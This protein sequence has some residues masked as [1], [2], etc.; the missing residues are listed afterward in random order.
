MRIAANQFSVSLEHRGCLR[1]TGG[2]Y[3]LG[4]MFR[5]LFRVPSTRPNNSIRQQ[6]RQ[7]GV[8][9]SRLVR[10]QLLAIC[11]Y[12]RRRSAN[13][14]VERTGRAKAEKGLLDQKQFASANETIGTHQCA[15]PCVFVACKMERM[16][17]SFD[18]D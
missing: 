9:C 18:Q 12:D 7:G 16:A 4:Y 14:Y 5:H 2:A 15:V 1:G 10:K 17:S 11:R 8:Y 3:H 13:N 6:N